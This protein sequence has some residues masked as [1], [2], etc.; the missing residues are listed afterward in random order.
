LPVFFV[1]CRPIFTGVLKGSFCVLATHLPLLHDFPL[2][3][4]KFGNI[5][6]APSLATGLLSGNNP[7]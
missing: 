6:S 1:D 2:Y 3:F 7:S 5:A 4:N